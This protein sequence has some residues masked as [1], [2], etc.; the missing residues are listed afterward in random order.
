LTRLLS[1][2][3]DYSHRASVSKQFDNDYYQ[4]T[5]PAGSSQQTMV[6][7][8]WAVDGNL[9]PKV[10]ILAGSR[11]GN[12]VA[13]EI[14]RNDN[15]FY[16][17]QISQVDPG[18]ILVL[19]V[20]SYDFGNSNSIGNY[21]VAADFRTA[22][23]PLNTF[24]VTKTQLVHFI[25]SG[26]RTAGSEP[27]YVKMTIYNENREPIFSLTAL[28]GETNSASVLLQPGRYTLRMFSKTVDNHQFAQGASY[29][30]RGMFRSDPIG[31]KPVDPFASPTGGSSNTP[32]P[33]NPPTTNPPT[34]EYWFWTYD[35]R[36]AW[37]DPYAL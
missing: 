12:E 20:G 1:N 36:L 7:T 13:A 3:W 21:I 4:I 6:A 26:Q 32:P 15:G 25:L 31:P 22:P 33:T 34:Y 17:V 5:A 23:I 18:S 29:L 27:I 19:K 11:Y 30:L 8:V 2:Q 16:T 37:I 35:S 9:N 24:D 10:T 14:I 28:E